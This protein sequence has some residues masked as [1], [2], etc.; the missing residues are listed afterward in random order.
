MS[1]HD[2]TAKTIRII[3]MRSG[4]KCSNPSC[5]CV[6]TGPHVDG[7]RS[8]NIGVAA[9]MCA[10]AR[11]GPRYNES[12]TEEQRKSAENGI[13][14]CQK[15][16][17]FI[18][19]DEKRY[20]VEL[21]QEWKIKSEQAALKEIETGI[22]PT[23]TRDQIWTVPYR[24]NEYFVGRE[25]CLS[26]IHKRL[27]EKEPAVLS[28]LGGIGKTETAVAYAYKYRSEY[29]EVLWIPAD[30]VLEIESGL[31]K[32][33]EWLW[34][35]HEI[36][37]TEDAVT[38]VLRWLD[39]N[40]GWLLILD[41]ADNP[42][43][44]KPYVP[45][46]GQGHVLLTSRANVFRSLQI[47][48]PIELPSLDNDDAV[49]FLLVSTG[50]EDANDA[51][52]NG[53]H[54]IAIELGGLPLALEQAA[55]YIEQG[56]SFA[57]YLT[58]YRTQ[59][60]PWLEKGTAEARGYPDSVATTWLLNFM[61][62]QDE[63]AASAELLRFTAFLAPNDIP[64]ELLVN[65]AHELGTPLSEALTGADQE[66]LKLHEV[67]KPLARYSLIRI[68][69]TNETYSVHRLVQEVTK[70]ALDAI[71]RQTWCERAIR[72]INAAL[73]NPEFSNW[74]QCER[75]APHAA[76]VGKLIDELVIESVEAGRVC[77][78]LGLYLHSQ[79]QYLLAEPLLM[80]SMEIART[81]VGEDHPTFAI[82]VNNN[83]L[84]YHSMGR[85]Q[86]AERFYQ[87]SLKI[88]R[89]ALGEDHPFVATSLL[90]LGGLYDSMGRYEDAE[91]L[92]IQSMEIARRTLGED[93]STFACSVNNLGE[94]YRSMGRYEDA[95]PLLIQSMEISRRTLGE[96]HPSF[97]I[98]LSNL[99][100]LYC[101]MERYEDAEPLFTQSLE[102]RRTALGEDHPS[103]AASL[104]NL[105]EIYRNVGRYSDAEPLL[106]QSLEIRRRALGEQHPDFAGSLNNL[107]A[108]YYSI[109]RYE[110]AEPHITQSMEIARRALGEDHPFFATGLNNLASLHDKNGRHEDAESLFTQSLEIRRKALGED[111]LDFAISV[112][113]LASLYHSRGRYEDAEPLMR[114]VLEKYC[115]LLGHEHPDTQ[116]VRQNY[117]LL[118]Q[119]LST[120]RGV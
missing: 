26:E 79:G 81:T 18:D 48:N 118:L 80:Q 54:E 38:N 112:S 100:L 97:A 50:R 74:N 10:A 90:N 52:R 115:S 15:C 29:E 83:A 20:S 41:N 13:W 102:I 77:G 89:T 24:K 14:L 37:K 49:K 96:D 78:C 32:T 86:E 87:Q 46:I 56:A 114:S 51:E 43:I 71:Q 107:G 84:L 99:A 104:D 106:T 57:D 62:V 30:T 95:E 5:C 23:E 45:F 117:E 113:K 70:H 73:P 92:L 31:V 85:Y 35:D 75:I 59:P 47:S 65:G 110:D 25:S 7:S 8:I 6:T 42:E 4:Y 98:N 101:S 17:R 44:L 67:L 109:G 94:L 120:S 108:L 63:S 12:Q 22:S 33:Y 34:P 55:S 39:A 64:F 103:V 58:S 93:H 88:R 76:V 40:P 72:A 53:A 2:F 9:H 111:H 16:S 36:P 3:A 68:E 82:S 105:A 116:S 119:E 91:P 28:G 19:V 69:R 1:R 11:G 60:V 21:L 27:L 66:P 61:A